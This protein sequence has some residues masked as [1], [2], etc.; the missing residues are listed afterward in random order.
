MNTLEDILLKLRDRWPQYQ[1]EFV[2]KS[3]KN[4]IYILIVEGKQLL[5]FNHEQILRDLEFFKDRDDFEEL[6][7]NLFETKIKEFHVKYLKTIR[8]GRGSRGLTIQQVKEACNATR[9]NME[10]SR[11]LHIHYQTW[12][13]YA[14]MYVNEK[15]PGKRTYF[16]TQLNQK[17]IGIPRNTFK[18][19]DKHGKLKSYSILDVVDGRIKTKYETWRF[20]KRIIKLGIIPEKCNIC[21]F[22]ERRISDYK[23]PLLLDYID[24]DIEN[25][26]LENIRLLCYNCYFLNVGNLIYS[27][28]IKDPELKKRQEYEEKQ[29]TD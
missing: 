27:K 5:H 29:R 10:A 21:G 20:K 7:L 17:A 3:A 23:V 19:T 18:I 2:L 26:K 8:K 15:D 14:K 1:I 22:E 9:S 13:K 6:T 16:E 4:N 25:K 11:Y 28:K 12:K 24:G